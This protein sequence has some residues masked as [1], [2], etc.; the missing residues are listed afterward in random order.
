M[1]KITKRRWLF[2][3]AGALL[4]CVSV[5]AIVWA[6]SPRK[7]RSLKVEKVKELIAEAD[8]LLSHFR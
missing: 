4:V 2:L 6:R 5:V 7:A 3:G 8:Q 1:N